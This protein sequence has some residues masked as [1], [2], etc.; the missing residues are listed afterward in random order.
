MDGARLIGLTES[1]L[2]SLL[3]TPLSR[4]EMD[5]EVWL[6]FAGDDLTLRVRCDRSG[7]PARCASWTAVFPGGFRMLSEAATVVG[8]W[9]QVHPDED[10]SGLAEPLIRRRLDPA[11]RDAVHSFTATVRNGRIVSVSAFDEAPDWE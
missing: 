5:A 10:A 6:V 7:D 8:L 2:Q 9:P 3:G 11:G 4:R 1:E